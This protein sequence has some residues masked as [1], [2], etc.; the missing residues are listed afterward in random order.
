MSIAFSSRA[1]AGALLCA[2]VPLP[3][4]AVPASSNSGGSVMLL[5]PL[6]LV[7]RDDLEFGIVVSNGVAGT[8]VLDPV[9]NSIATTGGVTAAG[10]L[11]HAARFTGAASGGP[12]VNIRVPNQPVMLTRV[13][14]TET[15]TLSNFTLDGP[16]KRTMAAAGSFDF[17]VGGQLALGT[18]QVAGTYLGTF[19]V[20]VQYP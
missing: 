2:S 19:V 13:G 16:D 10:G 6:T 9:N 18:N 15:V 1:L 11:R 7:K 4:L 8:V 17:A 12:V 20:T 14:G 3:A 5:R